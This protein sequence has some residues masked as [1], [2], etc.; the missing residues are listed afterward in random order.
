MTKDKITSNET[1]PIFCVGSMKAAN[2][3]LPSGL[4]KV[5][6]WEFGIIGVHI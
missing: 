1:I 2:C 4:A 3:H 5:K 6:I